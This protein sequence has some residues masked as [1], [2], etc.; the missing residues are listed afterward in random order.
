MPWTW[1]QISFLVAQIGGLAVLFLAVFIVNPNYAR[2]LYTDP[3]G[4]KM[5][6]LATILVGINAGS[7]LLICFVVNRAW[8]P[9]ARTRGQVT[10]LTLLSGLHF[11][12]F[13]LPVVYIILV[14]PA[15]ITIMNNLA[16]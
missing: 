5:S 6:L 13:G 12:L 7:Y 1:D 11:I 14:G 16:P 3:V 2:L 10:V 4:V 15:A 8:P 9:G